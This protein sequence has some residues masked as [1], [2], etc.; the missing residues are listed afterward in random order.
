MAVS[1][2]LVLEDKLT[3]LEMSLSLEQQL[4]A[5]LLD[6]AKTEKCCCYDTVFRH[7][8]EEDF[9]LV[10]NNFYPINN[11]FYISI[12]KDLSNNSFYANEAKFIACCQDCYY[13][14]V[15][16]LLE[17]STTFF[18]SKLI[19]INSKVN[20]VSLIGFNPNKEYPCKLYKGK[21][22]RQVFVADFC[23]DLT[24][25]DIYEPYELLSVKKLSDE[26]K[27]FISENQDMLEYVYCFVTEN[28]T[29]IVHEFRELIEKVVYIK[30]I[31]SKKKQT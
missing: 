31:L 28:K 23:K 25:E 20:D 5:L 21:F 17:N 29:A 22:E 13:K 30:N 27:I 16:N 12:V 6:K 1:D 19:E 2:L 24:F 26:E 8:E 14:I 11:M 15:I 3:E 18:V 7:K 10:C 4:V 9:P